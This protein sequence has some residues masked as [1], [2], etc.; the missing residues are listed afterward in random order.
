MKSLLISSTLAAVLAASPAHAQDADPAVDAVAADAEAVAT[1]AAADDYSGGEII[2]TAQKRSESAQ[3]VPISLTVLGEER[4]EEAGI[5]SILG[6]QRVVPSF[7]VQKAQQSANTRLAIRGI[8]SS[9]NSAIEPS[10]GAFVDGIYIPRPGSLLAGLNDIASVEVLRGPQGTLFGRNASM[11]AIS[12]HTTRPDDEFLLEVNGEYGSYDRRRLNIIA[13]TPVSDRA[14]FRISGLYDET[15]GF[16]K[17][18][19]TGKRF[20]YSRLLSARAALELE[21]TDTLTWTVRGDY[22]Q[23]KGDG[24]GQQSVVA[25]SF[26][27]TAR[28]NFITRTGGRV[29]IL[30]DTYTFRARHTT[31]GSLRDEQYGVASDLSL[32][33]DGF[34][35]RLL[36]SYR[37]WSAH[38]VED[39]S[40]LTAADIFGRDAR[41]SSKAHS[42]E[43]QISSPD[44]LFDDKLSFVAGLYYFRE[45]YGLDEVMNLG[46]GYCSSIIAYA[47]PARL[48][49]CNAGPLDRASTFAFEQETESMAG[50]GQATFNVTDRLH[51]TGGIRYSHDSKRGDLDSRVFN[52]A[53]VLRAN[54]LVNNLIFNGGKVT[55]RANITYDLAPD[56]IV[57]A[58]WA[59]GYKSGGFDAGNGSTLGRNRVFRPETTTNW[60]L[61]IKSQLLDRRLTANATLFRTDVND[62]QLRSYNGTAFSVR[63]A[64][65]IRQQGVEFEL[66]ARPVRGLSV[67]VTGTRLW[68][69]YT[70]FRNAPGLPGFG[71]VQDLTGRRAPTSPRWQGVAN[72]KYEGELSGSIGWSLSTDLSFQSASDIGTAGD[73]NPQT[74]QAAYGLLGARLSIFSTDDKWEAYVGGENLTDKGYCTIITSQPLNG[75]LGVNDPA[76]GGTLQRCVVGDPM[77]VRAGF[78]LR[79]R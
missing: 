16:G 78:K 14:A 76:T 50:Y 64:G 73:G 2:V 13:N 62:F 4:L 1:D 7:S 60:E 66:T 23:V 18:E 15:D 52:T 51:L 72:A 58:T 40:S 56:T 8:G 30:D 69:E 65:S 43:L 75:P 6:L 28:A 24:Q 41:F 22:Q 44:D 5:T 55:Y 53:N 49:A 34:T 46:S 17:N 26:T 67:G 48:A 33:A 68:S 38:Q 10:V 31:D 61:G 19:L 20:G 27:P 57:F 45:V 54:D 35:I 47:A 70:D 77:T 29:P 9:G 12:F 21:L 42:Q 59:T 79:F 11:G 37:K 32:D 39:D 3:K 36:S 63:N 74:V 71:G 25:D